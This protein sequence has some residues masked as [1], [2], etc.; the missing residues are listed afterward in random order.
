MP[1]QGQQ[2]VPGGEARPDVPAFGLRALEALHSAP[3]LRMLRRGDRLHQ[4]LQGQLHVAP[5]P[6]H[7]RHVLGQLRAV[8]IDLHQLRPP[9]ELGP[10]A[11]DPVVEP[12]PQGDDAVRPVHGGGAGVVPVHP[13]H[14]QKPGVVRGDTGYAHEGAA[15]GRVDLLRQRQ[16]LLLSPAGDKPAAEIDK[17]PVGGVDAL[18]R[19]PDA[20]LL[21]SVRRVGGHRRLGLVVVHGDLDILGHVHQHRAGTAG[22]RQPEG[23]PD[24]VRQ[25]LDLA[26]EV[27]VL[28]DGQGNAGDVDLLEGVGADLVVGN[29]ASDGHHGDGIQKGGGDAGNQIGGSGAGGGD[30][31]AGLPGGP[32]PAVGGVGGSLLVGGEY[33]LEFV[34]V[35]I[36]GIIDM[37]HL[38]AGI[39]EDGGDALL[40]Q[41][42]DHNVRAGQFHVSSSFLGVKNKTPPLFL[43]RDR[44]IVSNDLAVP[45]FLPPMAAS[46]RD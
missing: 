2:G 12:R 35:F 21:G 8:H 26:H 29:I 17:W 9:G 15:D 24:G 44:I 25:V 39:A 32:G 10:V 11:G 43:Q 13:L 36:Q 41:S 40:Q 14:P 45:L 34:P 38:P 28:G 4:P 22:D 5:H 27:V 19:L 16:Q 20:L 18:R 31:H 6:A 1:V 37:D 33:V 3:P 42:P 30:D 23:L 46:Q 7:R